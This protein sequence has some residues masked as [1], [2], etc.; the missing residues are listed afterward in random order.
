M[1]FGTP[2]H[3]ARAPDRATGAT[4]ISEVSAATP[5]PVGFEQWP[6][7]RR[8]ILTPERDDALGYGG[9]PLQMP[10]TNPRSRA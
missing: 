9:R 6:L 5:G 10:T 2:W 8:Q 4:K 3:P 7:R 1:P